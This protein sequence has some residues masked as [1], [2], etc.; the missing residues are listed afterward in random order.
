MT[1]YRRL[2]KFGLVGLMSTAIHFGV[3]SILVRLGL[4]PTG[5]ANLMAFVTAFL[6]ST[7][8]QQHFTFADRLAGQSLKKRS[9]LLLFS[10]NVV[11]AYVLGSLATGGMIPFLALVPAVLNYTLLH[12]FSGHPLFKR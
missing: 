9:V 8:L 12:I 3:L 5:V 6:V 2:A 11:A 1:L 4:L 7:T 10:T